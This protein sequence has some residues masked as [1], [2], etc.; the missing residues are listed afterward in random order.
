MNTPQDF[1]DSIADAIELAARGD[2]AAFEVAGQTDVSLLGQRRFAQTVVA[3]AAA[4]KANRRR[5]TLR[6]VCD[7]VDSDHAKRRT[8]TNVTTL[9]QAVAAAQVGL[10]QAGDS[11]REWVS[12]EFANTGDLPPALRRQIDAQDWQLAPTSA[13]PTATV[14]VVDSMVKTYR[15]SDAGFALQ[16]SEE[17]TQTKPGLRLAAGGGAALWAFDER[18]DVWAPTAWVA[19]GPKSNWLVGGRVIANVAIAAVHS[20]Y[21]RDDFGHRG[22]RL[23]LRDG[24]Q[25]VVVEEFDSASKQDPT[26]NWDNLVVDGAWASELGRAASTWLGV[27]HTS[28]ESL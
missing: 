22:V 3:L 14:S 28:G 24:S 17:P 20:F 13:G 4:A 1:I 2:L 21:D 25:V 19:R 11:L 5:L 6:W 16:T 27:P 8:I 10:A 23:H 18:G 15:V 26:Y 12:I 7:P 9:V